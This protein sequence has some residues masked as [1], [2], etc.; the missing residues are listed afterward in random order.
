VAQTEETLQTECAAGGMEIV[1]LNRSHLDDPPAQ[2][3]ARRE[4]CAFNGVMLRGCRSPSA[5]RRV[6]LWARRR[7]WR[8]DVDTNVKR[9]TTPA[10]A[11]PP[12]L[13][14]PGQE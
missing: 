1:R 7:L 8:L 11:E 14:Q 4:A 3:P 13:C 10:G 9:P 2:W 12:V 6:M 5:R